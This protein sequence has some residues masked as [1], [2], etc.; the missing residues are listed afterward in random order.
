MTASLCAL[1]VTSE[2]AAEKCTCRK[3]HDAALKVEEL[4]EVWPLVPTMPGN[5]SRTGCY[6]IM[7]PLFS[8]NNY[9]LIF[10]F[11]FSSVV[12][13]FVSFMGIFLLLP[14]SCHPVFIPLPTPLLSCVSFCSLSLHLSPGSASGLSQQP[15]HRP[16]WGEQ[17]GGDW[18][19]PQHQEGSVSWDL[20]LARVRAPSGRWGDLLQL[21]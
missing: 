2:P 9:F 6:H 7:I 3:V 15:C 1:H 19:L 5:M 20:Q 18:S 10:F 8:N 16:M 14:S 11:S 21:K 13:L 12:C 17:R 4:F